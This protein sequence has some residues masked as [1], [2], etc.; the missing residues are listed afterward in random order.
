MKLGVIL[1][2]GLTSYLLDYNSQH[3]KGSHIIWH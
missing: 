3:V 2:V 1:F